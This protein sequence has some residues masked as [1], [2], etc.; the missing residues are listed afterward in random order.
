MAGKR[1]DRVKS[2]G[3]HSNQPGGNAKAVATAGM[4]LAELK[5][6]HTMDA[7]GCTAD[8]IRQHLRSGFRVEVSGGKATIT[9]N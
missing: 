6:T 5:G 3:D 8:Q 7:K 4:S 9:K 1:D 2:G